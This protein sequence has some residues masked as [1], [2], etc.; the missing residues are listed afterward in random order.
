V[1]PEFNPLAGVTFRRG[2]E[3]ADGVSVVGRGYGDDS[4]ATADPRSNVAP[5]GN[6]NRQQLQREKRRAGLTSV[7]AV[8]GKGEWRGAVSAG[9]GVHEGHQQPAGSH[10]SK[11]IRRTSRPSVR[12][13]VC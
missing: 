9:V 6:S 3:Q 12:L 2:G 8:N 7:A 4:G 5:P 1:R 11:P 10:P 13:S